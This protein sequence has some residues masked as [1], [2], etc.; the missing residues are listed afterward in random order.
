MKF[1]RYILLAP[2]YLSGALKYKSKDYLGAKKCFEKALRI[3]RDKDNALLFQYYGHTLFCLNEVE[4]A[5]EYFSRAC[6]TY[7]RKGWGPFEETEYGLATATL[8]ALGYIKEN[9][10]MS[11]D[12]FDLDVE[13]EKRA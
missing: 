5:F 1:L 6:E 3:N 2:S 12:G 9:H 10:S 11:I 7:N 4:S 8:E 13:I